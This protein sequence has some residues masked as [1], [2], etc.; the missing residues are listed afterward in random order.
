MLEGETTNEAKCFSMRMVHL[1]KF[2][3]YQLSPTH[4]Q[5]ALALFV[6]LEGNIVVLC[7]PF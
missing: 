2:L 7:G 3:E 4:M 1:D 5:G 6:H